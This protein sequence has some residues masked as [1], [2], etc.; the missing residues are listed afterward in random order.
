MFS[1]VEKIDLQEYKKIMELNVF[2]PLNLMQKVI[3][4]MRNHGGGSIINISSQ[5]STKYI[6]N[7]AGYA[8]TKF[9]L[10]SLSLTARQELAKDHINVSIIRPGLVDTDFGR[11]TDYPEPDALRAAPDGTLLPYVLSPETVAEKVI[12]LIGSGEAEMNL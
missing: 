6:P 4:I 3:P 12:E 7:I 11:H 5:A 1:T 2:A 10:N 8:S 9:A